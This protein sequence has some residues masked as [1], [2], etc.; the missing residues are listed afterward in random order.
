MGI[1]ANPNTTRYLLLTKKTNTMKIKLLLLLISLT[2]I[3]NKENNP[4]TLTKEKINQTKPENKAT[5]FKMV[6]YVGE[7]SLGST[8]SYYLN[9]PDFVYVYNGHSLSYSELVDQIKKLT[10]NGDIPVYL[11]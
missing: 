3:A 1:T 2:L 9:T 11:N 10:K 5:A 7:G 8:T 4:N 6:A